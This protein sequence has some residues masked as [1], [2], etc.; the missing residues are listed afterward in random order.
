MNVHWYSASSQPCSLRD[1]R[2]GQ[3]GR[4]RDRVVRR[5]GRVGDAE[6][7]HAQLPPGSLGPGR[8]EVGAAVLLG[9]ADD[10]GRDVAGLAR[11]ALRPR[12]AVGGHQLG[13]RLADGAGIAL[14]LGPAEV[15]EVFRSHGDQDEPGSQLRHAVLRGV[16]QPPVGHVAE[17]GQP[18]ENPLPVGGEPGQREPADVLEQQRARPDRPAQL[19]RPG[20]Q[21][22]LVGRAELLAR[23][24]ERRAG[25]APGQQVHPGVLVGAP[26][27]GIGGVPLRDL[28]LRPVV[29]QGGARV[30]VKLDRQLVLEPG[31]LKPERLP[32]RPCADLDH[33]VVRQLGLPTPL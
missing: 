5:R 29:P 8:P 1:H 33:L 28:P 12:P 32:A 23:D 15:G 19:D 16:Q 17:L 20:E 18:V 27:G 14:R 11:P 10:G 2:A 25:H 22:A 26:D 21:V 7:V 13:Q 9:A 6:R 31:Q 3:L 30:R 4:H 24:R